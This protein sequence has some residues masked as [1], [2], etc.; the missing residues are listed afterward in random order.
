MINKNS[1]AYWWPIIKDLD[2]PMPKTI[3]IPLELSFQEMFG[4]LDGDKESAEA[5]DNYDPV[6]EKAIKVVGLPAFIRT[7][8]SSNKHDW[9]ESCY[10]SEVTKLHQTIG[11]LAEFT[12]IADLSLTAIVVREYIEMASKFTAFSGNMPVNPER[13]YFIKDGKIQCKHQYWVM[14]AIA[15]WHEVYVEIGKPR[16]PD[17][18]LELLVEMNTETD[19]EIELLSSYANLVAKVV[20]GYWSVDFCKAKDGRWILIDMALGEASW[21]DEAC[22]YN[23]IKHP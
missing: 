18:W 19:E 21:H 11:N 22:E 15:D 12:L 14:E 6:I 10:L 5:W 3:I 16:L 8:Y 20:D 13:R 1:M 7:D 17:N 23:P 9:E 2:I 4:I